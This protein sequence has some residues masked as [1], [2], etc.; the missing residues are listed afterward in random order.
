MEMEDTLTAIFGSLFGLA[1]F[2]KAFY[3]AGKLPGGPVPGNPAPSKPFPARTDIPVL[4][5]EPLNG[6]ELLDDEELET[7]GRVVRVK[8]K[9][10]ARIN[11]L[12]IS[13]LEITNLDKWI[14]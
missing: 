8:E 6:T 9:T 3:D 12:N 1:I 4:P 14:G 13:G 7:I 2:V 5:E 10:N 11:A